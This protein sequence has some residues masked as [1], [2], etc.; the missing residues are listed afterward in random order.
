VVDGP[1]QIL[2]AEPS[3]ATTQPA[4]TQPGTDSASAIGGQGVTA[5]G[6]QKRFVYDEGN[7]W[8][9]ITG[10]VQIAHNGEGPK[11]QSLLL[12]YAKTVRADFEGSSH[13][14]GNAAGQTPT[15]KLKHLSAT[16]DMRIYTDDKTI[17]CGEVDFDPVGQILTCLPGDLQSVN[18]VD[19][20]TLASTSCSEVIYN[21]KTNELTKI[22]NVT[23][24]GR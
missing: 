16:G 10:D 2:A 3:P 8:A 18:F 9:M 21:M 24:Q 5:I 12:Q 6:W 22:T 1:G 15:A 14:S 7:N 23:G 17:T 19:N 11:S 4:A 13:G 20:K